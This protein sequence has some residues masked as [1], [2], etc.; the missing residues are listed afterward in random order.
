MTQSSQHAYAEELG[1]DSDFVTWKADVAALRKKKIRRP[2][3]YVDLAWNE[4]GLD[5]GLGTK[6][7][8]DVIGEIRAFTYQA[9][10]TDERE[11]QSEAIRQLASSEA[12]PRRLMRDLIQRLTDGVAGD[13]EAM[14]EESLSHALS[15][16]AAGIVDY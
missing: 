6:R 7:I 10:L 12:E 15:E 1:P 3:E 2:S 16:Y 13:H 11:F 5:G 9:Y 14:S 4:I 8:D